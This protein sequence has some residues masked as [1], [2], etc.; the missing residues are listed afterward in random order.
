MFRLVL[1]CAPVAILPLLIVQVVETMMSRSLLPEVATE[2]QR[3]VQGEAE[4]QPPRAVKAQHVAAE[5]GVALPLSLTL[6]F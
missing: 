4:G 3:A 2:M 6:R 5:Q 1:F